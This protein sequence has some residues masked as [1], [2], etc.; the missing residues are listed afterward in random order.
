[1]TPQQYERLLA[2]IAVAYVMILFGYVIME[3]YYAPPNWDVFTVF[4][5]SYRG[6]NSTT[7]ILTYGRGKHR[8]NGYYELELDHTY[9]LEYKDGPRFTP[10]TVIELTEV[11]PG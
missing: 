7:I 10:A 9:Y 5:I 1:V 8:L 3:A 6:N 11:N 4:D 2:F